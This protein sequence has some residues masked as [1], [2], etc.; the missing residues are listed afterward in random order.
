MSA[1]LRRIATAIAV[2]IAAPAFG[3]SAPTGRIGILVSGTASVPG[4]RIEA[5]Q[6]GLKD[7][8]YVDGRTILIEYRYSEGDTNRLA[9][10]ATDLMQHEPDLLVAVGGNDIGRALKGAA[11]NTPIVMAGGS[12]PIGAGLIESLSRPGGNVTGL[13]SLSAELTGKRLEL[14]RELVP[15][16]Y[17]I[18]VLYNPDSR[19]KRAEV[20]QMQQAATSLGLE[21]RMVQ[22]RTVGD[23]ASAIALAVESHAGAMAVLLDAFTTAYG[24]SIV[25]LAT[26]RGLPTMFADSRRMEDAGGLAAY[27][28][29][30]ADM[31]RRAAGYVDKIL[32]GANPSD[33]PV[34]QPS[35]FE[36]VVNLETAKALGIMIPQSILLRADEVIE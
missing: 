11:G 24:K 32:K 13:T 18:A 26:K 5:F 9:Q 30:Y 20:A 17:P 22:V 3:Q 29:D 4:V 34:E 6:Q 35:K 21:L 23:I 7:L 33:L 1:I 27:G 19:Q 8:G 12:D 14:I 25:E 2:L 15:G 36:L 31:S 16:T 10:L 28:P